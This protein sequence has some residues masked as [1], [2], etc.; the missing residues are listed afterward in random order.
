MKL[1]DG[2][3]QQGTPFVIP[4]CQRDG[5]PEF[6]VQMGYKVGAEIGVYKGEFTEKFCQVGLKMFAIDPWLAFKGQGRVQRIQEN[7]DGHYAE[8]CERLGEY[9]CSIIRATSMDAVQQ[10]DNRSLD[11]VYIDGDHSLP[12]VVQ[13][14]WYWSQKVRLGGI[15]SGHDYYCTPPWANNAIAHGEPAVKACAQVL[16]IENFYVFGGGGKGDNRWPS[17]MWIKK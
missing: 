7:Q 5:L 13:D 4:D 16:G 17:W 15:V 14:I 3:R 6:F 8:A 12:H 9:D 2:I 11:F 10:F 1:I